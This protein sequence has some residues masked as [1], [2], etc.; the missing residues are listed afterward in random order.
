MK[1]PSCLSCKL[2]SCTEDFGIWD[3]N[4]DKFFD[5]RAIS[6]SRELSKRIIKQEIDNRGQLD[7]VNDFEEELTRVE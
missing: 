1:L 3:D 6:V 2:L 5:Q 4:Y 7:L